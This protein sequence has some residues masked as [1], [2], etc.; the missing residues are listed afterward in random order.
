MKTPIARFSLL[1]RLYQANIASKNREIFRG[2]QGI[3]DAEQRKNAVIFDG[4]GLR[5][6]RQGA[7]P[8]V[9]NSQ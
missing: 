2:E 7:S 1:R 6:A 5:G 3:S 4:R 9:P 8:R